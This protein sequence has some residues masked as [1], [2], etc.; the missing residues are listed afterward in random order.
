MLPD[1][2]E[3]N[4]ESA[5]EIEESRLRRSPSSLVIY[6]MRTTDSMREV[7][8]GSLRLPKTQSKASIKQ[9]AHHR[10]KV[11]YLSGKSYTQHVEFLLESICVGST[12]N[13]CVLHTTSTLR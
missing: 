5:N 11:I 1:P 13:S 9:D 2:P 10:S 6:P 12:Y 7:Y 8:A 4:D 3:D